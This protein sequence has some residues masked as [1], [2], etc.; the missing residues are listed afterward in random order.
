MKLQMKKSLQ[1]RFL[2]MALTLAMII[3]MLPMPELIVYA[4]GTQDDPGNAVNISSEI[5]K[6]EE[7][8]VRPI[9]FDDMVAAGDIYGQGDNSFL[10]SEQNELFLY[11]STKSE[12]KGYYYDNLDI[13]K[14]EFVKIFSFVSF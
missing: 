13:Y 1:M 4:E 10:L 2:S 3:I 11:W 14:S 12:V 5:L 8:N 6:L 7:N 9:Q